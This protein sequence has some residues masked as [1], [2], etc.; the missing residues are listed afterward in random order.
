MDLWWIE[1]LEA[2]IDIVKP[3][4]LTFVVII[5]NEL[6][7]RHRLQHNHTTR[8]CKEPN[9]ARCATLVSGKLLNDRLIQF[10]NLNPAILPKK[11]DRVKILVAYSDRYEVIKNVYARSGYGCTCAFTNC[12]CTCTRNSL[13]SCIC[14]HSNVLTQHHVIWSL[15]GLSA[16]AIWPLSHPKLANLFNMIQNNHVLSELQ[17]EYLKVC[18]TA[19]W[20]INKT[21]KGVWRVLPLYNQGTVNDTN[22]VLCPVAA[23][24]LADTASFLGSNIYCYAM[25]SELQPGSVIE[26]HTGPCNYRL[27]CHIPLY[28]PHGYWLKV[29]KT[30]VTWEANTVLVFDDSFVH[31]VWYESGSASNTDDCHKERIV[32]IIDIWHP[33]VTDTE[34]LALNYIFKP[35]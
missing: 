34:R 12:T 15:P 8:N 25:Y 33:E 13:S 24:L 17:K 18:T 23:K 10:I 19:A 35:I 16:H 1:L 11:L 32:F 6:F 4:L 14:N 27:R 20:S 2:W 31:T 29:G 3:L 26:P 7:L 5:V 30:T 9:C 21:P 28:V 22:T